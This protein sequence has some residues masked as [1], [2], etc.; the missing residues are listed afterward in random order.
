M[1]T[2]ELFYLIC[3]AA[4]FIMVIY[5][6]RRKKKLTSVFF[7]AITGAAALIAVNKFGDIIGTDIPLNA[8]NLTGSCILG[9][10][11]VICLVLLEQ[12]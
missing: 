9:V 7:G 3:S 2:N 6:L 1:S 5:Y 10:P 11:F 4:A 8:F 12:I